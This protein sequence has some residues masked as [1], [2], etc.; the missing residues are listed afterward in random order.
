MF[1]NVCIG[2]EVKFFGVDYMDGGL[3]LEF[4]WDFGDGLMGLGINDVY[5]Y[6]LEGDYIVW[7]IYV[8][9]GSGCGGVDLVLVSI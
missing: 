6:F 8:E 1:V 7:M 2:E 5:R 3:G 9:I 4:S